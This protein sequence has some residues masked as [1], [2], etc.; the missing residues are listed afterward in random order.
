M[1]TLRAVADGMEY[2]TR[3]PADDGWD[4][5]DTAFQLETT[6]V[7]IEENGGARSG[8]WGM[9]E[10]TFDVEGVKDGDSVWLVHVRYST[11]DTFGNNDGRVTFMDIFPGDQYAK[12][13]RLRTALGAEKGSSLDFEDKNYYVPFNGYFESLE[14][15][16]VTSVVVGR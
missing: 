2:Q 1:T 12:A 3:F 5:G 16:V 7:T 8:G 15:V 13:E 9:F 10:D 6:A 14:D 11:G 4:R